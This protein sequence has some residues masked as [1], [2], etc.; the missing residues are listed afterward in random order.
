M[1]NQ[2]L[3]ISHG[4]LYS[5]APEDFSTLHLNDDGLDK[6]NWANE[7]RFVFDSYAL[8]VLDFLKRIV[9]MK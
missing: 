3:S 6:L 5:V 7:S 1:K 9:P 4:L 8:L 2:Q